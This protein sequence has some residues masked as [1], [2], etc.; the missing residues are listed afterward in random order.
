VLPFC[1][2]TLRGHKP[3]PSGYP[4]SLETIG[5]H[6]RK[7]RLDLKLTQKALAERLDVNK[8]TIRFW[9]NSQAKPSLAKIL[10]I[11]EFLG[12]DPFEKSAGFGR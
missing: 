5:D 10:K 6:I 3:P 11:I 8:D 1:Y 4:R 7:R 2:V 9:E 12:Y